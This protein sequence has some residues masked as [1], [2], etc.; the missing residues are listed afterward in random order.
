LRGKRPEFAELLLHSHGTAVVRAEAS[1]Y[2]AAMTN[3]NP[4]ELNRK[5]TIRVNDAFFDE[6]DYVISQES[7]TLDRSA[8]LRQLINQIAR[9]LRA[10]ERK[11]KAK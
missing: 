7:P 6:L 3:T 5:L 4:H 9:K 2:I 11:D 10:A 8:Y 1:R